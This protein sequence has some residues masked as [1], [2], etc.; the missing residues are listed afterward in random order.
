MRGRA[1]LHFAASFHIEAIKDHD[2]IGETQELL[3]S[4]T[5]EF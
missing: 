4:E 3:A 5:A 1:L 2:I